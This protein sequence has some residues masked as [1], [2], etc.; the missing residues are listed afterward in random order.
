MQSHFVALY[1]LR[2]RSMVQAR[3]LVEGFNGYVDEKIAIIGRYL[4]SDI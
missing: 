1:R 4:S 3:E 2:D